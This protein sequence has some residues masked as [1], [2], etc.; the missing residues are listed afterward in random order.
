VEGPLSPLLVS[1]CRSQSLGPRTTW[2][3]QGWRAA[4]FR[5]HGFQRHLLINC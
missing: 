3:L 2:W 5:C 1:F 4:G